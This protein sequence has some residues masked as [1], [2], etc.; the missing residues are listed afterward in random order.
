LSKAEQIFAALCK[1]LDINDLDWLS[2]ARS[3]SYAQERW[4]TGAPALVERA[5]LSGYNACWL[6][7]LRIPSGAASLRYSNP[8]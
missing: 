4:I 3:Q 6:F 2:K 1:V 8:S 7:A 5:R